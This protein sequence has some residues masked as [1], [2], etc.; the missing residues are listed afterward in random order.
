M[1]F[2]PFQIISVFTD[3]S[4]GFQGNPAACVY[5]DSPM[6]ETE[7][8]AIAKQLK[9]PATSFIWQEGNKEGHEIRWFAPDG[10][11]D[12]C[13]HGSAAAAVYLGARF[14]THKP[15]HLTYKTGEMAVS[16]NKDETFSVEL[17]PIPVGK[18]IDTPEAIQAGLGI[19]ILGMYETENKHLILTDRESS[20]KNMQPDFERLRESDIFGYAI[21]AQGDAVDFVSR[22][23]VPHVLQLED[24]AT[25]SSHAILVPFWANRLEK[26][27]MTALQLSPRGGAFHC[28]LKEGRVVLT[29]K[30]E[31]L[32][33]GTV[34][35]G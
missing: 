31:I 26:D 30:Y 5:L 19:P 20:V 22:T 13:G 29:G 33:Q 18:E 6:G 12:L 21:T 3:H 4:R 27:R 10:E 28:A 32:N 34:S 25:G 7:M 15:I 16:W 8:K 14:N 17:E 1:R 9:M 11:I 2:I 35:I 24:H 23:L